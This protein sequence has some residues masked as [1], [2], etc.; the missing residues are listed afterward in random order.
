V[1]N[2]KLDAEVRVATLDS[3]VK[4][5]R[6]GA[7]AVVGRLL[8]DGN[9][10]VRASAMG[11]AFA[12]NVPEIVS[13]GRKAVQDEA[14][15]VARAAIGGLAEGDA[16]ELLKTWG[17]RGKG[18]LRPA[19]R[20][21]AYLS[22][23]DSSDKAVADAM[24]K[25]GAANTTNVF[26]LS[27]HGGDKDRGRFVFENHGACLQCHKVKDNGGI[28][29]PALDGIGNRLSRAQILESIYDPNAVVAPGYASVTATM[30]DDSIVTGRLVK[31]EKG[32]LHLIAPDGS[33]VTV[34]LADVAEKT[35]PVSAMPPI[36]AA[37]PPHDLRDLV[38]YI[39]SLRQGGKAGAKKQDGH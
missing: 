13:I 7:R 11:H 1:F 20:L 9:E 39:S 30:K 19:L 26:L 37:L 25:F 8:K 21:D 12:V 23:K 16:P 22:M 17:Q 27:E 2:E 33:P 28:Q 4:Q 5:K 3:F 35:P 24:A 36:G 10:R 6:E 29:G 34:K 32:Q 14:F 18:G 15:P 31:E 38:A